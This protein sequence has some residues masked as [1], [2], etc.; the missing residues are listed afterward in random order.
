MDE[1][2]RRT[3]DVH[4]RAENSHDVDAILSTFSEESEVVWGGRSYR[5]LDAIRKLHNGMGFGNNGAFS[6]LQVIERRRHELGSIVIVEQI[7]SGRHTGQWEGV[8]ATGRI[9]EVPVCTVYEF[10]EAGVLVSERPHL[11][12]WVIWK[13]LTK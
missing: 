4:L 6:D 13:Q 12:R 2:A 5:G 3:L 11:D 7:L 1:T 10:D 8:P 9:F